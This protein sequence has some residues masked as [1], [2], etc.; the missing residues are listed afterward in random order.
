MASKKAQTPVCASE[1]VIRTVRSRWAP[2][3]VK[4]IADKEPIHFSAILREVHGISTKVLSDQLRNLQRGGVLH[5]SD[6]TRGQEVF[7]QLTNRGRELKRALDG[8]NDL[9]DRWQDL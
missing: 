7:Y 4:V 6:A 9:A 5:R 2:T 3:L 8:L 1:I